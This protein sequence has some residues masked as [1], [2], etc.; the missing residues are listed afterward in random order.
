MIYD[1]NTYTLYSLEK[2]Y[3]TSHNLKPNFY[4]D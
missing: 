3:F 4:T 1:S 2:L